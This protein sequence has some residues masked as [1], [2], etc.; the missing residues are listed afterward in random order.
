LG[1]LGIKHNCI[2]EYDPTVTSGTVF[3]LPH[4]A[5]T[6][7]YGKNP[8][9]HPDDV[10]YNTSS[11]VSAYIPTSVAHLQRGNL[12]LQSGS[13][14]G[15]SAATFD[16]SGNTTV[17]IPTCVGDLGRDTLKWSYGSPCSSSNGTY[18]PGSYRP[19]VDVDGKFV[20]T[21]ATKT[22]IIP[23]TIKH[24][25]NGAMSFDSVEGE[26]CSG[27]CLVINT[28]VCAT[29]HTM[30]AQAFYTSSDR[31]L[32][33]NIQSLASYDYSKADTIDFKVFNFKDDETKKKTYGVIAQDVQYAGL[34]EIVHHDDNGNLSVDYISLLIL[35]LANMESKVRFLTNEVDR[36]REEL[37]NK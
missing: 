31:N 24:L 17:N 4:S 30:A 28:D 5:L 19:A 37:S 15:F 14:C 9:R 35:K 3:T 18:D 33:E 10:V 34:D 6:I 22:I 13:T 8:V 1:K 21:A 36:L 32:K 16:P 2:A 23:K 25:T 20:C 27:S 26:A 7:S 12:T 29:G 11:A